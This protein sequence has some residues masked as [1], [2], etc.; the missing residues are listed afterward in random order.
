MSPNLNFIPLP[1]S[2][3]CRPREGG[4]IP[5]LYSQVQFASWHLHNNF[6]TDWQPHCVLMGAAATC[7]ITSAEEWWPECGGGGAGCHPDGDWW[8]PS[9]R[10]WS[11]SQPALPHRLVV[12]TGWG[13]SAGGTMAAW[14]GIDVAEHGDTGN[15]RPEEEVESEKNGKEAPT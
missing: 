4:D 14:G 1:S 8:S 7:V 3:V 12:T 15:T 13:Q 10:R 9:Q 5:Q 6:E 2:L 11:W